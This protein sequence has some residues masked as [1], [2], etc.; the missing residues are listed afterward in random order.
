[1]KIISFVQ[2]PL[3][4]NDP[5]IFELQC[6]LSNSRIN[7]NLIMQLMVLHLYSLRRN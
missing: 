6:M 1:M 3:K 2:K 5:V 7:D 4:N